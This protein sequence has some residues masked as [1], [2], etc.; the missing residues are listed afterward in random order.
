MHDREGRLQRRVIVVGAGMAGLHLGLALSRLSDH[1]VVLLERDAA[2]DGGTP[3]DAFWSWRRRG[4][5]HLRQSHIFHP[6]ILGLY[7]RRHPDLLA[8]LHQAGAR[9]LT[10]GDALPAQLLPDY[11]AAPGDE[12]CTLLLAR[13]A[14]L[15]A[16]LRDH[17][18][19]A[20]A[21]EIIPGATV[22]GLVVEGGPDEPRLA[23]LRIARGE[24]ASEIR[25]DVI[26][27]ASGR[28]TRFPRWLVAHGITAQEEVNVDVPTVYYT[29]YYR[30]RPGSAE[31]R[32]FG[33]PVFGRRDYLSCCVYPAD[34]RYF[35]VTLTCDVA[36]QAL[37][38]QLTDPE[39]FQLACTTLAEIAPWIEADR[40]EPV[41]EVLGMARFRNYWRSYVSGGQPVL[42]GFFAIGDAL[43]HTNPAYG[44]GCAWAAVHAEILADTLAA[45]ADPQQQARLFERRVREEAY[46]F[47]CRMA[48]R[49]RAA[50]A[51]APASQPARWRHRMRTRARAAAEIA[52]LGDVGIFRWALRRKYMIGPGPSW[53]DRLFLLRR[54]VAFG[55]SGRWHRR[56][57]GASSGPGREELLAL[58]ATVPGG[59]GRARAAR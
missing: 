57:A 49:D 47:C 6:R 48:E 54:L 52:R 29:R 4:V 50:A 45:T 55:R 41:T 15:E 38:Q 9:E 27:D 24:A 31:P 59:R 58:L 26:V 16:V 17:V 28:S 21:I 23:G 7:R 39:R 43:A 35:S 13:R 37:R 34:N 30:L 25:G 19:R 1:R 33:L 11:V 18:L 40:A 10:L 20:G 22:C 53:A 8:A 42:R 51:P 5:A 2:P 32:A 12:S 14:T 44:A 3:E 56:S 46:P 36:D